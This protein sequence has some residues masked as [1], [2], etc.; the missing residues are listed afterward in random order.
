MDED[1]TKIAWSGN[2]RRKL[3]RRACQNGAMNV[4]FP[5]RFNEASKLILTVCM[6]H[7]QPTLPTSVRVLLASLAPS[8]AALPTLAFGLTTWEDHMWGRVTALFEE[9][10]DQLLERYGGFWTAQGI[11]LGN[12]APETDILEESDEAV[13]ED[14]VS[15][16]LDE[17]KELKLFDRYDRFLVLHS[18]AQS[19]CFIHSSHP[20]MVLIMDRFDYSNRFH[21]AQLHVILGQT[22]NMLDTYAQLLRDERQPPGDRK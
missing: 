22:D 11:S 21:W 3:W 2:L 7:A 20:S 12:Q 8:L 9:R 10:V 16:V 14:E 4:R 5:S 1:G 6:V 15:K 13:F 17:L 19:S 18:G